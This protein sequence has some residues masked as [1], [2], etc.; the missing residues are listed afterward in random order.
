MK[1]E[2]NKLAIYQTKDGALELR[3]DFENETIWATQAQIAFIFGIERSV[4]TKH[5]NNLFKTKEI[6]EKSNVQNLHIANSDKPVKFY[7]LDIILAVGYRT[8]SSKAVEFR[9][10][11]TKTLKEHITQGF[12]INP[13]RIEKNHQAFL[14]AVENIK[15]L[16]QNNQNV[17]T[18]DILELIKSFSYTWFSLDSYDKASFPKQG[19][20]KEI[21]ITAEELQN[22]LQKLK[23]DLIDKK[24]ATKMFAQ[25]KHK[26]SLTG[27]VG[28]VFQTIFGQ[29]AYETLEEKSA[30]LLYFIIKNHPF[31][32]GNKR[33]G[34]FAFVWFLQKAG[35]N[36]QSKIT[37]ETLAT[38]TILIAE[39]DP[40][41]K[42]KMI[43][44]ILLLLN[45]EK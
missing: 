24:E 27:I 35:F 26:G 41:D 38:L 37:P 25:E 29:D 40:K 2:N 43:G 21:Q 39:S 3:Q 31:N 34:A 17:Q 30:H 4:I 44:I 42:D 33:S 1:Q 22:D 23:K 8:K 32:D 9:K 14:R 10:W 7:S 5:I 20:K 15:L 6:I 19:T 36:F 11:A 28:N 16:A 13:N 12:T 45:F 18:S